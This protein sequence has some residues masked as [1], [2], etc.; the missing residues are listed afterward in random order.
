[1]LQ[2]GIGK[3]LQKRRPLNQEGLSLKKKSL[4]ILRIS[5]PSI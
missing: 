5:G 4:P 3:A 1:M 2:G